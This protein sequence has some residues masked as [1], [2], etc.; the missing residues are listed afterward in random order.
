MPDAQVAVHD[1]FLRQETTTDSAGELVFS[2]FPVYPGS[3]LFVSA[4]LTLGSVVYRAK[5]THVFPNPIG[6]TDVGVLMLVADAGGDPLTTATGIVLDQAGE[7][8]PDFEVVVTSDTAFVVT[9]TDASGQYTVPGLPALDG[10]LVA[11]ASGIVEGRSYREATADGIVPVPGGTTV[12]DALFPFGEGGGGGSVSGGQPD[13]GPARL[14]LQPRGL[15]FGTAVL[16]SAVV[17]SEALAML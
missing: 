8:L 16:P 4:E 6:D 10:G 13:L 1:R 12:L 17:R 2:R 11:A 7:P 15:A 3:Q 14:G 5:V 9:V